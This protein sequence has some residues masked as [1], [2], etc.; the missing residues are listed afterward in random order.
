MS[1]KR[2]AD[3]Q[4]ER[5]AKGLC[6]SCGNQALADRS[7]CQECTDKAKKKYKE[8]YRKK[9][10][11]NGNGKQAEADRGYYQRRKDAGLCPT[12][13]CVL[14]PTN[15]SVY[16]EQCLNK[17]RARQQVAKEKKAAKREL[18]RQQ[19]LEFRQVIGLCLD[20][21]SAAIFQDERCRRCYAL[22]EES[23]G[24]TRH[25]ARKKSKLCQTCDQLADKTVTACS[26]CNEK[27]R[28]QRRERIE[29][30]NCATCGKPHDR[31]GTVCLNCSLVVKKLRN[32]RREAGLCVHCGSPD[33]IELYQYC[34]QCRDKNRKKDRKKY[35]KL[36]AQILQAY[37]GQCQ[38]CGED[39]P[40]FLQ[41]DHVNDDGNTH[42]RSLSGKNQ[43]CNI[44][45]WLRKNGFPKEGFQLL[46]AN[47]NTAKSKKKQ[48]TGS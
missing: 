27:K 1:V 30:G 38:H 46:C 20:C 7:R 35:A 21:E 14:T 26:R 8:S 41:I 23:K 19:A 18:E 34:E 13:G 24:I 40:D 12:P 5:K 17:Q 6:C 37:R 4:R 3:Y 11:N 25:E 43:G 48:L 44:Y 2:S 9:P 28:E 47:C 39:N 33:R 31:N 36:K 42:R 15:V 45:T 29:Q 16:C 22:H 32:T 10:K